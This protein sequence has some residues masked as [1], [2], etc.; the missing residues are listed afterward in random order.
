MLKSFERLSWSVFNQFSGRKRANAIS[1]VT[2]VNTL[3]VFPIPSNI[4]HID[5]VPKILGIEKDDLIENPLLAEKII[6]SLIEIEFD[7]NSGELVK[8]V[9]TG[10]SGLEIALRVRHSKH[11]LEIVHQRILEFISKGDIPKHAEFQEIINFKY[12]KK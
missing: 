8:G 7:I 6:P 4:E 9:I 2:K 5:Y 11:D 12:A 3:E 1:V 10:V